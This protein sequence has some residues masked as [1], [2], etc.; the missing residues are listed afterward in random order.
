MNMEEEKAKTQHAAAIAGFRL[1]SKMRHRMINA[2][3]L[4]LQQK[5]RKLAVTTAY[6]IIA[7]KAMRARRKKI[8]PY[9]ISSTKRARAKSVAHSPEQ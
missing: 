5:L 8:H 3:T 2:A 1:L 7:R 9:N 6:I 4:K